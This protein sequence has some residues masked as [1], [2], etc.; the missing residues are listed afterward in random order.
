MGRPAGDVLYWKAP[1]S[2][3]GDVVTLY[4]GNIDIYF[5]NDA[6]AREPASQDEFIWLRGNNIDLVHKLPQTQQ[7]TPN[8]NSTYSVPVNEV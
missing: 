5:A 7:F 2:A 8:A 1:K 6:D 3:L 4:D